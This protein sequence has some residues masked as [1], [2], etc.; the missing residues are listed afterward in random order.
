MKKI[1]TL[2]LLALLAGC[3][4]KTDEQLYSNAVE[5]QKASDQDEALETY[6][7]LLVKYPQSPRV[8]EA[9]YAMGTIHQDHKKQFTQAIATYQKLVDGYPDHATAPNA[10][11][12]IGF[13][14]NNELKN[15]EAA[16]AAYESFLQKYPGSSLVNSAQFELQHLGKDPAQI[17]EEQTTPRAQRGKG[18]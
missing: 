13:I 7:E 16:R 3:A 18:K 10:L 1:G 8:P 2:I 14:N 4:A 6:E 17:L 11:F 12:L 5:A 9:L 15:S